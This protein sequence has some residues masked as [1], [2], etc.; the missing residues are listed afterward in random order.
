MS[1][2]IDVS[3]PKPESLT[4]FLLA[5]ISEDEGVALGVAAGLLNHGGTWDNDGS[6]VYRLGTAL[7]APGRCDQHEPDLPNDCDDERIAETVT[8]DDNHGR[9]I[10]YAVHIARHDPARILAECEAKRAIVAYD[11]VD[12][13]TYID[14]TRL[15]AL[16]Y[17]DHPDYREEWRP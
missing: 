16:P 13:A 5:R 8:V 17:A 4:D 9:E 15:L 12:L 6:E 10:A 7:G 11:H 1:D 14:M 3:W 2:G